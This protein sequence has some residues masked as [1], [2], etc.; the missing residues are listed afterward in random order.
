VTSSAEVAGGRVWSQGQPVAEQLTASRARLR[1]ALRQA[2]GGDEREWAASA[3]R[4]LKMLR[5]V[6][7]EHRREVR[8][9]HCHY[10]ELCLEAQWLIP[11]IQK[12]V[13]SFDQVE[14]EAG[15]L[16]QRLARLGEGDLQ[17]AAEVRADA[18]HMLAHL[19]RTLAE[20]NYIEFERFN[21]PPALD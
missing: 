15:L 17:A 21:E 13:S 8:G 2:R 20:E 3:I 19:R 7:A 6:L 1:Q 4:A 18:T 12:L 5:E 14:F 10:E 11:R 9:P 16:H